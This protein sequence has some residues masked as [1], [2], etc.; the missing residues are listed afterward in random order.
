[1][2]NA[3]GTTLFQYYFKSLMD[4]TELVN[5]FIPSILITRQLDTSY[6]SKAEY[7]HAFS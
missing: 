7:F 4:I 2:L 1:M 5:S 3:V 6:R